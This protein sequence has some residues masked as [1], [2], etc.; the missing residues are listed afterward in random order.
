MVG[1]S[2]PFGSCGGG[3]PGRRFS[4]AHGLKG[5]GVVVG[6]IAAAV[7]DAQAGLG[8]ELGAHVAAGHE[9]LVVLLGEDRSDEADHGPRLGKMPTKSVRRRSS[10]L[11][12]SW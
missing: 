9:P 7:D 5:G 12:R 10:L 6:A 3:V 2:W 11:S 1:T 4:G 8:Q